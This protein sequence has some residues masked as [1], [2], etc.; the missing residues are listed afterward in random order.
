MQAYIKRYL[1]TALSSRLSHIQETV[2]AALSSLAKILG[3]GSAIHSPPA[4]F[5]FFKV[6]ISSRTNS[7]L[8]ARISPQWL[9]ELRRLWP[10]VPWKLCVSSF[11]DR[12]PHYT[13]T[14][15]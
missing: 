5:F 7:T 6:E 11:P 9:S 1:P 10:N 14:A 15:A 13:W 2:M 8:W 4:L 12:F 3:E